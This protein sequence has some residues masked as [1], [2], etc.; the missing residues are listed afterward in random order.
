MMYSWLL[1]NRSI[2]LAGGWIEYEK[3]AI[4]SVT[5]MDHS[6]CTDWFFQ[7]DVDDERMLSELSSDYHDP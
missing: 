4:F 3:S 2:L 6:L 7:C 1:R 5:E